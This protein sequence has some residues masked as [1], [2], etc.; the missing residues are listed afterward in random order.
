MRRLAFSLLLPVALWN[1]PAGADYR[2]ISPD[3]F[4]AMG[5]PISKGRAFTGSDNAEAPA[6]GIINE[7][8]ARRF[9]PDEDPIGKRLKIDEDDPW[10]GVVGVITDVK[11]L[12][13][14][15]QSRKLGC[16]PGVCWLA[17]SR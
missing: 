6:V 10:M 7:T 11:H 5:I 14:D 15:S 8:M 2:V 1:A 3:Y 17:V 16:R 9:W 13:L 4:R 12:G